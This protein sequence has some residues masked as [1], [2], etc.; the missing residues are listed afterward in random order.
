M[1]SIFQGIRDWAEVWGLF[2]PLAVML[3]HRHTGPSLRP[4]RYYVWIGLFVSLATTILYIYHYQLPRQLQNNNLIYNIHSTLRVILF[5]WFILQFRF[6]RPA[7]IQKTIVAGYFAFIAVNFLFWTNPL[8][9]SSIHFI[10]EGIAL[11]SLC[12]LFFFR[13]IRDE[14]DVDWIKHP[15]FLVCAGIS[16][17]EAINFFI[18][19]F[20]ETLA[21]ENLDFLRAAWT[22]HNLIFVVLCVMLALGLYRG[23]KYQQ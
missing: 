3:V 6:G 19:L 8:H 17:Y 11:L 12:I 23:K 4:V 2:L 14:S 20:F 10:A 16:L 22:L 18:F 7:F 21:K 5:S 15:A 9:F 1:G 13:T